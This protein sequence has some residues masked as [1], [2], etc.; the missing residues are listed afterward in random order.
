M[1]PDPLADVIRL[2][3]DTT[4]ERLANTLLPDGERVITTRIAARIA[5]DIVRPVPDTVWLAVLTFA[6]DADEAQLRR[7]QLL[8]S[9]LCEQA[10]ALTLIALADGVTLDFVDDA[11]LHRMGLMRIPDTPDT[12]VDSLPGPGVNPG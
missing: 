5:A 12:G 6:D 2:A 4:A 7:A 10:G 11:S 8:A 3:L 9:V 1:N